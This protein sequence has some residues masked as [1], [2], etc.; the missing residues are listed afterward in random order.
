MR[1]PC[2][3]YCEYLLELHTEQ[4]SV[5]CAGRTSVIRVRVLHQRK[6]DGAVLDEAEGVSFL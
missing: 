4:K 5:G 6:I 3:T 1:G 2:G